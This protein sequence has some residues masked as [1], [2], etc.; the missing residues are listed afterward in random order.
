MLNITPIPHHNTAENGRFK[1]NGLQAVIQELQDAT[2]ELKADNDYAE[3][4]ERERQ[5]VARNI[6]I[7]AETFRH[8]PRAVHDHI[9]DRVVIHCDDKR[10]V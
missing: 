2:A 1:M 10:T 7:N 8:A 5:M 9:N 4:V 6:A 3:F